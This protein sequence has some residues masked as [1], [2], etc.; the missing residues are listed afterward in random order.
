MPTLWVVSYLVALEDAEAVLARSSD[1]CRYS[2][3]VVVRIARNEAD[4]RNTNETGTA[5]DTGTTVTL[6]V[7]TSGQPVASQKQYQQQTPVGEA[8]HKK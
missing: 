8:A 7:V 4:P 5:V 1:A 3:T 2:R 6:A